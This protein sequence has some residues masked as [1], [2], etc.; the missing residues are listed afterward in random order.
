MIGSADGAIVLVSKDGKAHKFEAHRGKAVE[1]LA[2]D[3][4]RMVLYSASHDGAILVWKLR[5]TSDAKVDLELKGALYC[6]DQYATQLRC[7]SGLVFAAHG[8]T[9]SCWI[10][11]VRNSCSLARSWLGAHHLAHVTHTQ[12]P[13]GRDASHLPRPLW[14]SDVAALLGQSHVLHDLQRL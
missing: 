7:F 11:K 5:E 1:A 14:R 12:T 13:D 10:A 4:R 2:V 9:V 3:E 6:P 8:N